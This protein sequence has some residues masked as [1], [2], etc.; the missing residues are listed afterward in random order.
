[1]ALPVLDF[2]ETANLAL[3]PGYYQW[4]LPAKESAEQIFELE[5][6]QTLGSQ[7]FDA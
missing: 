4:R 6:E 7:S 2:D 1:M 5:Y 3:E